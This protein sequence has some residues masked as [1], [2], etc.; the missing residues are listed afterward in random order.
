M[1]IRNTPVL[2]VFAAAAFVGVFLSCAAQGQIGP[3]AQAIAQL[4]R[5]GSN[6]TKAH[7]IEFYLYFPTRES[8][9]RAAARIRAF[10]CGIKRLD[11]A[12]SGPGWL[13]LATKTMVP[14]ET[15]LATLREAFGRLVKAEGGEYDGWEAQVVR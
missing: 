12:A 15:E 10:G 5:A 4:K 2:S 7:P 9:D 8:A 3:D 14:T 11:R 6:L 1:S 13:V